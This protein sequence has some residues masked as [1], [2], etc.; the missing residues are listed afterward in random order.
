MIKFII[1]NSLF[2]YRGSVVLDEVARDP[3]D[4]MFWFSFKK[5]FRRDSFTACG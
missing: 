5:G 3:K 1:T 4:L 2:S